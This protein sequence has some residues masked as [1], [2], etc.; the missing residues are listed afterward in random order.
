M[1]K[2]A[3]PA[4]PA[5]HSGTRPVDTRE[6]GSSRLYAPDKI[7]A[8]ESGPSRLYAPRLSRRFGAVGFHAAAA[9]PQGVHRA[10]APAPRPPGPGVDTRESGPPRLHRP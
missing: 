6:S 7:S 3:A 9:A 1:A 8:E 10:G 4:P 5:G 2:R